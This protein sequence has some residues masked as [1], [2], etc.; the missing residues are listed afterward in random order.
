MSFDQTASLVVNH[1]EHLLRALTD[2]GVSSSSII[3]K[4]YTSVPFNKTD[5]NNTNT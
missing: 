1:E 3:L 5:E 4:E 2:T